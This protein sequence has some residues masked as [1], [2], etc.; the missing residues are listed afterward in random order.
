MVG[1]WESHARRSHVVLHG[2]SSLIISDSSLFH[3]SGGDP[4]LHFTSKIE[5]LWSWEKHDQSSQQV[6]K[7]QHWLHRI[8][9]VS[10]PINILSYLFFTCF[11][12]GKKFLHNE[13]NQLS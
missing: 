10:T 1:T 13:G 8:A 12:N 2:L 6:K 11:E 4:I 7:Y 9:Y 5:L 3:V